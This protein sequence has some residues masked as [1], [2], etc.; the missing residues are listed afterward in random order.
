MLFQDLNRIRQIGVIAARHGF[1]EWFERA[2][3]WR[4]L[5][6]REKVEVPTDAQP[7]STARR[8]RM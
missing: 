4:M 3:V 2:G 7:I 6:R 1:G 5:G 8:F